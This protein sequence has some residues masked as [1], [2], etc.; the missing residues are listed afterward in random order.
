MFEEG[1]EAMASKGVIQLVLDML[2]QSCHDPG[3]NDFQIP[4]T[5]ALT[6]VD[7]ERFVTSQTSDKVS[8]VH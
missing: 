8:S 2:K 3:T 1:G 7:L 4:T 6:A 5:I